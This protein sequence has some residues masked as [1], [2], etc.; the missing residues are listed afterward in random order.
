MLRGNNTPN[1]VFTDSKWRPLIAPPR[2]RPGKSKKHR[3]Y[4]SSNLTVYSVVRF[5]I[6][7]HLSVS[8]WTT[9]LPVFYFLNNLLYSYHELIC[10][11]ENII[12]GNPWTKVINISARVHCNLWCTTIDW[13]DTTLD[14]YRTIDFN[15]LVYVKVWSSS[16]SSTKSIFKD[17]KYIPKNKI[18]PNLNKNQ[19]RGKFPNSKNR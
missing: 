13:I 10:I 19:N 16:A 8:L 18:W 5:I 7:G 3:H 12:V 11:E 1:G 9:Q 15:L 6:S 17:R 4:V 2:A 14:Y